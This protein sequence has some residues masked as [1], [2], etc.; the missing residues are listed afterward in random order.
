MAS[1]IRTALL[2]TAV[3]SGLLLSNAPAYAAPLVEDSA[4]LNAATE[5]G[6]KTFESVQAPAAGVPAVP[7]PVA[8]V[9]K[10]AEKQSVEQPLEQVK[11]A[12]APVDSRKPDTVPVD[13]A[14]DADVENPAGNETPALTEDTGTVTESVDPLQ[15]SDDATSQS[16]VG[17]EII[18]DTSAAQ[19]SDGTEAPITGVFGIEEV[20]NSTT[21]QGSVAPEITENTQ[22]TS[23][24]SSAPDEEELES[25]SDAEIDAMR[26]F[27]EFLEGLEM[28][29]GSENWS[30]KQW[31]DYLE[32]P[33]GQE[34]TEA[35]MDELLNTDEFND[36]IDIVIDYMDGEDSMYLDELKNYLLDLFGGNEEW[37]ME[38]YNG[39]ME[40]LR[41]EGFDVADWTNGPAETTPPVV[42]SEKPKPETKPE[43]KPAGNIKPVVDKKPIVEAVVKPV[44]QAKQNQLAETGANGTLLMGGA[45]ALL[46]GGG[47][48]ALGVRRKARKH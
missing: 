30:E 45:G 3:A 1:K 25:G 32:T 33:E 41:A 39:M 21:T 26:S 11:S 24:E 7:V 2:S 31:T 28:P 43:I 12:P 34:F 14:D 35:V 38:A 48:L 40:G 19:S 22:A 16:P 9:E 37:A 13:V 20:G 18:T 46:I 44:V 27:D 23:A 10:L 8:P 6:E 42:P 15:S 5:V 36:L 29:E 4:A 17:T 47:V